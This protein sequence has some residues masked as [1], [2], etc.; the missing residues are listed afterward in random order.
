MQWV[1]KALR[2][3]QQNLRSDLSLTLLTTKSNFWQKLSPEMKLGFTSMTLSPKHRQSNG[4]HVD[5]QDPSSSNLKIGLKNVMATVFWDSE[6]V[7]LIDYLENQR[8]VTGVYY[9]EVLRKLKDAMIKT[10]K[11]KLHGGVL[12]HHD[13]A[14]AHSS[15]VAQDVLQKFR[16]E[17]LPHP[18][19]SPDL[20][21]SG[22]FLFPKLKKSSKE[23]ILMT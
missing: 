19:Y 9:A 7:I 8:M 21:P 20:A 5:L 23:P 22:F 3:D 17:V 15:R 11:G 13:N 1:P 14:L 4:F 6:G 16:W 2:P 12:F 18:P 10:R